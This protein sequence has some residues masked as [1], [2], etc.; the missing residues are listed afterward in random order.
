MCGSALFGKPPKPVM[1]A[2]FQDAK[3]PEYDARGRS[4]QREA[5]RRGFASSILMAMQ[6]GAL[7]PPATTAN[8]M[9]TTLG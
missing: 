5:R 4:G 2:Q 1:P 7:V 6:K 3:S 8:Q 9:K